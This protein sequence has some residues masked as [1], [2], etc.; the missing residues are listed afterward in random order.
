MLTKTK[1]NNRKLKILKIQNSTF[2]KTI[3]K[4]FQEKFENFRM[5]FVEG[6]AFL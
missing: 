2:V 5:R 6:A 1:K 4:K 3:Q